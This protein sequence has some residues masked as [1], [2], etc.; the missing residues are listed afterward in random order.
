MF[1]L[2]FF[3]V[4]GA[5]V[6]RCVVSV[7]CIFCVIFVSFWSR[8]GVIFVSF[9]C[10]QG[11]FGDDRALTRLETLHY[12]A[13]GTVVDSNVMILLYNLMAIY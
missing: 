12:R 11:S 3:V 9:W 5:V 13:E 10:P 6:T 4:S 7:S 8:F 2:F 1:L